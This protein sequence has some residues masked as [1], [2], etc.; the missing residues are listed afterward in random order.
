M[1]DTGTEIQFHKSELI[2]D[3][4]KPKNISLNAICGKCTILKA[5]E[6]DSV[7][8][9]LRLNKTSRMAYVCR[10]KLVKEGTYKLV[11]VSG[12]PNEEK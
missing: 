1:S 12:Q 3:C 8:E 9:I 5:H 7:E 6:N 2:E 10:Y 11:P 4:L